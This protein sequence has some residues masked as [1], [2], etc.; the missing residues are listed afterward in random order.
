MSRQNICKIISTLTEQKNRGLISENE[1]LREVSEAIEK[2][3]LAN[4]E[5]I[6][7]D[8]GFENTAENGNWDCAFREDF[9]PRDKEAYAHGRLN[10]FFGLRTKS[11]GSNHELS[12]DCNLVIKG[13]LPWECE[14]IEVGYTEAAAS[15]YAKKFEKQQQENAHLHDMLA[16]KTMSSLRSAHTK[17]NPLVSSLLSLL[18]PGLGHIYIGKYITGAVLLGFFASII[19]FYYSANGFNL[20]VHIAFSVLASIFAGLQTNEVNNTINRKQFNLA[21]ID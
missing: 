3:N 19:L 11:N 15:S 17:K 1:F 18:A 14:Q 10:D 13:N 7:L 20:N 4:S 16:R 6:D 2:H 12:G 9:T 5:K 21:R 8:Y